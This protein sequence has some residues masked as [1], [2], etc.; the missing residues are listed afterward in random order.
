LRA[1]FGADGEI[2]GV[3]GD[4][5]VGSFCD[6]ARGDDVD[7]DAGRFVSGLR[8]GGGGDG[9][10]E[11]RGDG[12]RGVEAGGGDGADIAVAAGDAV[13]VPGVCPAGIWGERELGGGRRCDTGAGGD[14]EVLVK[15]DGE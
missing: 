13:D 5:S 2:D 4:L 7:G 10:F 12:G 3:G 1:D 11:D 14:G 15:S 8:G 9:Y 6:D